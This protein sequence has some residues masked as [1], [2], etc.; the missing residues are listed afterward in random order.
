MLEDRSIDD[1]SKHL[2][3]TTSSA[4]G[5]EDQDILGWTLTPLLEVPQEGD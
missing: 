4:L 3:N 5:F 2:S 1:H